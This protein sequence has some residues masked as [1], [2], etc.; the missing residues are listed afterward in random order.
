MSIKQ[1]GTILPT[2]ASI[3]CSNAFAKREVANK[4]RIA[5]VELKHC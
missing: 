1:V 2:V 4:E 3:N 5:S